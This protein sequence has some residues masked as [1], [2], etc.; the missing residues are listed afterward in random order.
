MP[1]PHAD[2]SS[3]SPPR[4]IL[5]DIA[6]LR[7]CPRCSGTLTRRSDTYG[8][9]VDCLQCGH[10]TYPPAPNRLRPRPEP[11][12]SEAGSGGLNMAIVCRHRPATKAVLIQHANIWH[13]LNM[14][15]NL[16]WCGSDYRQQHILRSTKRGYVHPIC[17]NCLRVARGHIN[18]LKETAP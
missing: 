6:T 17:L 11:Y 10:H 7:T 12:S 13:L 16:L 15:V 9:Y 1:L 14:T 3:Y 4:A 5:E 18:E 8:E 2:G